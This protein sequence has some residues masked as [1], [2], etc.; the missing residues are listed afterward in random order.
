SLPMRNVSSSLTSNHSPQNST[1]ML[2]DRL[3]PPR[4]A[5]AVGLPLSLDTFLVVASMLFTV[6]QT[7]PA[8][9]SIVPDVRAPV[10]RSQLSPPEV[11]TMTNSSSPSYFGAVQV[12]STSSPVRSRLRSAT[13]GGGVGCAVGSSAV[14][15]D[16]DVVGSSIPSG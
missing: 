16:S 10:L 5:H 15:T 14:A 1:W 2:I 8:R 3:A 11:T 6:T 13:G 9:S 7:S 12:T 4:H